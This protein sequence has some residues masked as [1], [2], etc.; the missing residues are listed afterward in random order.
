MKKKT[1]KLFY[2][3]LP[4][5]LLVSAMWLVKLIEFGTGT[6]LA[7]LGLKPGNILGLI[8]IFTMPFLHGS[9]AHII[10][11]TLP[12]LV[13]STLI[14]YF[15]SQSTKQLFPWLFLA[16]GLWT[17]LFARP[18]YHIGASGLLYGMASFIFFSGVLRRDKAS[19][20]LS[21]LIIFLYSSLLFGLFPNEANI[22][23]EGHLAGG[24]A[25]MVYAYIARKEGKAPKKYDWKLPDEEQV[26][27]EIPLVV[28]YIYLPKSKEIPNISE[29]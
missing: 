19:I 2:S 5:A 7:Y 14:F 26:I 15:Y 29:D 8:G 22:S 11:N 6:S 23:W 1:E 17:W 21:F 27:P 10:S 24:V 9:F 12:F 13:L 25:G 3:F 4:G 18:S 28:N 20:A 16:T